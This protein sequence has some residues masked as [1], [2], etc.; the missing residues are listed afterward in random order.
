MTGFNQRF[1][2]R[3]HAG[4][5]RDGAHVGLC[6]VMREPCGGALGVGQ[7]LFAQ[8]LERWLAMDQ[9]GQHG[10]GARARQARIEHFDHHINVSNPLPNRLAREVHVSGK[11]LNCHEAVR[12]GWVKTGIFARLMAPQCFRLCAAPTFCC[13]AMPQPSL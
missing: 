11:P 12:D 4:V 9:L 8:H 10:V 6:V 5:Q 7:I 13:K 3:C 1:G 2:G